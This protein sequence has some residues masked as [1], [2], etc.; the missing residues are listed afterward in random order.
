MPSLCAREI[1]S[2]AVTTPL[3]HL[4]DTLD[5]A[6]LEIQ[7][8]YHQLR[9][10]AQSPL[11]GSRIMSSSSSSPLNNDTIITSVAPPAM[12]LALVVVAATTMVYYYY[13]NKNHPPI[14]LSNEF[15]AWPLI[16]KEH[17]S[18]DTRRFTFAFPSPHMQLGLPVGQHMTLMFT[19]EH[20][21]NAQRSY[22]P[23]SHSLGRVS[24]CIKVYKPNPPKFP[25]GG[26]VSQHLDSL[27]I[28]DTVNIRGPKG[29]LHYLGRG[30]FTISHLRKPAER[31]TVQHLGMI[32]GGTGITPM[33]QV[34]H[35][36]FDDPNDRTQCKLIYA[37][38]STCAKPLLLHN[39]AFSLC[40]CIYIRAIG[41]HSSAMPLS[42]RLLFCFP[43]LLHMVHSYYYFSSRRHFGEG[44]IDRTG[45]ELSGSL[46]SLLHAGSSSPRMDAGRRICFER[47]DCPTLVRRTQVGNAHSSIHVW[48][49]HDGKKGVLAQFGGIGLYRT[50][51]VCVLERLLLF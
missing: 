5:I 37:N 32:A 20:G 44:R 34:L 27:Q 42:S 29:H 49:T 18:H 43:L 25:H 46:S 9:V 2:T 51:L 12:A 24:F 3:S 28:G 35:A 39:D 47:N 30:K 41:N 23:V 4:D 21:V 13:Y 10:V 40:V 16:A 19:D 11:P 48:T 38:Q 7:Y 45:R 15:Q 1:A 33:L 17:L 22:T 36:I 26:K 8:S 31:R 50:R 6:L 14:A